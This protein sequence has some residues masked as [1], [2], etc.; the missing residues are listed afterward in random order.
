MSRDFIP[1]IDISYDELNSMSM[2][3]LEKK[4]TRNI[5]CYFE[6]IS[7]MS[8]DE[9]IRLREDVKETRQVKF[10]FSQEFTKDIPKDRIQFALSQL[11]K[12]FQRLDSDVKKVKEILRCHFLQTKSMS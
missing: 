10:R 5:E 3:Q 9:K 12:L 2:Y 7:N 6:K 11:A 8:L 4:V 1:F